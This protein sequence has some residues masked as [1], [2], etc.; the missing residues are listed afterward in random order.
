MRRLGALAV[1]MVLLAAPLAAQCP[2]G[3]P[4]PCRGA[5]RPAIAVP[6]DPHRIA[7]LPFRVT[8][9][10]TLLGEGV[11]ELIATEFTGES[12]PRAAHMGSVVRAWRQA[13]VLERSP[14]TRGAKAAKRRRN[15]RAVTIFA[16]LANDNSQPR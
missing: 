2:D 10:D 7:I 9:A 8:A 12:G 16:P 1:L 14:P 5:A 11:A 6:V 13:G 15:A 4:P 3:T